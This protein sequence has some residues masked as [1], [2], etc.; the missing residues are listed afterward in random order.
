MSFCQI[1]MFVRNAHHGT[2]EFQV[3]P[4]LSNSGVF[5]YLSAEVLNELRRATN[6]DRS[7]KLGQKVW[8]ENSR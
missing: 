2:G 4:I 3:Y 5:Y 1:F 7:E 6:D 8:P